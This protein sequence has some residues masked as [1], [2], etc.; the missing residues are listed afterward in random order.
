MTRFADGP[1]VEVSA[2]IDAS[3]AVVWDLVTDINLPARF[4][5]EFVEAEWIDEGPA[6][7]ARFL[8]RNQR[9]EREWETTSWVVAYE[10]MRAFGWAVHDRDNPVATWTYFLDR[11]D[12]ATVLRYHRILGPGRSF[13]TALIRKDPENE[14]AIVAARD[15]EHRGHMQAVVDGIKDLA[16]TTTDD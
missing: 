11:T 4:Q 3:A 8:G 2:S 5:S 9:G 15:E 12:R 10:P 7:E 14:E 1:V 6:L 16:E 13:I